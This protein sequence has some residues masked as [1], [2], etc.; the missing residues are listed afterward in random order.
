MQI[1]RYCT[2]FAYENWKP[3]PEDIVSKG[4]QKLEEMVQI[5][6]LQMEKR[7][8]VSAFR[9]SPAGKL[10]ELNSRIK[11]WE[12]KM[13]R[14]ETFLKKLNRRKKLWERK[15]DSKSA[16]DL[17]STIDTYNKN[18]DLLGKI[19]ISGSCNEGEKHE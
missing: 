15:A 6:K 10:Q 14:A 17:N 12:T 7:S 13:K 2:E 9:E 5:G 18:P 8:E 16:P 1:E 11:V 4:L 3:C 19:T